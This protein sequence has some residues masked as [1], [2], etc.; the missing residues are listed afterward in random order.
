VTK[1]GGG[2]SKDKKS[3]HRNG[4]EK[5]LSYIVKGKQCRQI[6]KNKGCPRVVPTPPPPE[7]QKEKKK[8]YAGKRRGEGGIAM[9]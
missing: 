4:G 8:N 2:V 7:N 5:L 6:K 1:T 9:S 3:Q